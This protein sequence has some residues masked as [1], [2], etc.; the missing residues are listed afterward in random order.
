MR[1]H[2]CHEA[3]AMT[4]CYPEWQIHTG[5][6]LCVVHSIAIA[7]LYLNFFF[8]KLPQVLVYKA[9]FLVYSEAVD[10]PLAT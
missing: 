2:T 8:Q 10:T 4:Q 7:N 5:T 6:D 1:I 9:M 3:L